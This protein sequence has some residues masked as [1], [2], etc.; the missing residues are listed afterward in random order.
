VFDPV[1]ATWYLRNSNS[2]G[3]AD[4]GSFQYGLPGWIPVVGKWDGK[5]TG[6]GVI[7][8]S[9]GMWYLRRTATAGAA[10]FAVFPYGLAG[11]RP[12]VG[13][14]GATGRTG[15]GM[16]DPSSSIWY[17]RDSASPGGPDH[18]PFS[19][20]L[21]TWQPLGG[22]W[23]KAGTPQRAAVVDTG[24][25]VEM[26]G[27]EELASVVASALV[28]LRQAGLPGNTLAALAGADFQVAA[29]PDGLLA[30]TVGSLVTVDATA[31]WRGWYTGEGAVPADRYDLLTVVLHELGNVA[32][33]AEVSGSGW[34]GDVMTQVLAPG[35]R[36]SD[37]LDAVFGE[38]L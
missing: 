23:I 20:G 36:R 3:A 26:L 28:R 13:D 12:V 31:Q 27:T 35:V 38:V 1:S 15:I 29:L 9:S 6:I 33:V 24:A 34:D 22:A 2:S 17:L 10:D 16:F 5:T 8:P 32:G 4:A 19:Y 7:D 21:G 14:W 30:E 11:W 37:H 18:T 25:G